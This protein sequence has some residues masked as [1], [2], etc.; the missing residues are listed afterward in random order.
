MKKI[1]IYHCYC[2]YY[3]LSKFAR[4][5]SEISEQGG[6]AKLRSLWAVVKV[7]VT[8]Y[9]LY[10]VFVCIYILWIDWTDNITEFYRYRNIET[11]SFV[12]NK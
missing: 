2:F 9:Y 10:C 3:Y 1:N 8:I 5:V 7:I 11:R 6:G 4:G 12:V